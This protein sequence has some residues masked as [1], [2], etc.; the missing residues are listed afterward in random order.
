MK[1]TVLALSMVSA[2]V[3]SP[4]TPKPGAMTDSEKIADALRGGPRFITND[5]TLLDWPSSPIA[6]YR[7]LHKGTNNWVCLPRQP[8]ASAR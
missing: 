6:E 2:I 1:P 5:A 4:Q 7:I 3:I 8:K